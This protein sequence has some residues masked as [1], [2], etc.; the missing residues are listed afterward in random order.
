MLAQLSFLLSEDENGIFTVQKLRGVDYTRWHMINK[1]HNNVASK[2]SWRVDKE[3]VLVGVDIKAAD[4][5]EE[6]WLQGFRV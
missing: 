1:L 5:V 3:L 4:V 2:P 6:G